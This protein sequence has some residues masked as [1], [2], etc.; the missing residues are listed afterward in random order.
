VADRPAP[1]EL[2]ESRPPP[3]A[4]DYV[5]P[6]PEKP[7]RY[8]APDM[9]W[10]TWILRAAVVGVVVTGA[11]AVT[12][13]RI[14]VGKGLS[15]DLLR[16]DPKKADPKKNE[17]IVEKR[18]GTPAPTLLVLSEPAGATVLV[19]GT[20]VGRTPWAGDNVWPSKEPLRVEVRKAG[21][22]SWIGMT[23]GGEQATLEATLRKR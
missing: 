20:E 18:V 2:A 7:V 15:L 5:V 11:W 19:G 14:S 23:M 10:G 9:R 4:S 8:H 13:G 17:E 1:V 12:T 3:M 21:Y 22:Q 16:A 6:P